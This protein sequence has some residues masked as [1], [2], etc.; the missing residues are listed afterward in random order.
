MS[1]YSSSVTSCNDIC[2]ASSAQ[3]SLPLFCDW[4]SLWRYVVTP[5]VA[6]LRIQILRPGLLL[7]LFTFHHLIIHPKV[8]T[9]LLAVGTSTR[10]AGVVP[11]PLTCSFK[12]EDDRSLKHFSCLAATAEDFVQRELGVGEERKEEKVEEVSSLD[13]SKH[14]FSHPPKGL[15]HALHP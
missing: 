14:C 3:G 4:C 5:V 7:Y 15:W 9:V 1:I 10:T 2:L 11:S 6:S 12:M 8:R 13:P